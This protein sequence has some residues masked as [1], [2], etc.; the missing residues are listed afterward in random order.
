MIIEGSKVVKY[1]YDTEQQQFVGGR[2]DIAADK[3][4]KWIN[5][6]TPY[7]GISM[8]AKHKGYHAI[9]ETENGNRYTYNGMTLYRVDQYY[10]LYPV[11]ENL[12]Q[13]D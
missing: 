7:R 12:I 3:F 4:A 1:V 2:W 6:S 11:D 13:G 8:Y 9:Y 5:T 10:N